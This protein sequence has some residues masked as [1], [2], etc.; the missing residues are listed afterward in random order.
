MPRVN[1][2]DR[3]LKSVKPAP[4]GKRIDL[5][6]AIVPGL[7]VRVNDKG[8]ATFFLLSRFPGSTNP[9][10]RTIGKYGRVTLAQAREQSR[11]WLEK[12]S[13]GEDPKFVD[14]EATQNVDVTFGKVARDYLRLAVVGPDRSNPIQRKGLVVER[15]LI[16]EFVQGKSNGKKLRPALDQRPIASITQNDILKVI[17]DAIARGAQY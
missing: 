13:V 7:G 8:G 16:G 10:R 5:M 15:Q 3:T 14:G 11:I 6:D 17:D 4:V 2:T 9:T 12:I 1:L